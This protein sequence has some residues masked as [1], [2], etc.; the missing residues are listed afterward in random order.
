MLIV[1]LAAQMVAG[2][3]D[4]QDTALHILYHHLLSQPAQVV[5]EMIN[6]A[7]QTPT[8]PTPAKPTTWTGV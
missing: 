7:Y 6:N 5:D 2:A 4:L 3:N 1:I 8:N